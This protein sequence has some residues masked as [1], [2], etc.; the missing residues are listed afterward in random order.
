[1]ALTALNSLFQVSL[2][3]GTAGF[4]LGGKMYNSRIWVSAE[5][6]KVNLS[7]GRAEA[8]GAFA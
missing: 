6:K 3:Q 7:R 4:F 1:M 8:C 5:T 2:P